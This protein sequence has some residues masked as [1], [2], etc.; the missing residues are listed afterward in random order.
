MK[1]I[2]KAKRK[3]KK[4]K[5]ELGTGLKLLKFLARPY[6]EPLSHLMQ[7]CCSI[8]TIITERGRQAG[9]PVCHAF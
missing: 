1:A 4:E 5:K 8:I 9:S 3:R 2:I 7:L 6:R